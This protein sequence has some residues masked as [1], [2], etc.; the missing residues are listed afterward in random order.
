MTADGVSINGETHLTPTSIADQNDTRLGHK[1]NFFQAVSHV[2]SFSSNNL[3][4]LPISSL[5]SV[6]ANSRVTPA[7]NDDG[8]SANRMFSPEHTGRPSAPRDVDTTG[9][10]AAHASSILSR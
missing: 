10:P 7:A 6:H 5:S 9:T 3:P 4:A 1:S 2:N 8:S